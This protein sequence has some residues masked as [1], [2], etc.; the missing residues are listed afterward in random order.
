MD[1]LGFSPSLNPED[2]GRA[3]VGPLLG[4][5]TTL[6]SPPRDFSAQTEQASIIFFRY[7]F[8][9]THNKSDFNSAGFPNYSFL[10][11]HQKSDFNSRE[12]F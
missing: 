6:R 3:G 8:L 11:T 2:L 5:A 7:S 10:E 4:K 12:Y 9:V 1:G